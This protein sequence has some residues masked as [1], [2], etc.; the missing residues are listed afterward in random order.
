[1]S[2][3]SDTDSS[4]YNNFIRGLRGALPYL[5]EYYNET[6]V[7]KISGSTLQQQNLSGIIDDLIL[8]YRIGIKIIIVHGAGPQIRQA[9]HFHNHPG[10]TIEGRLLVAAP[11][12][13]IVQ[14]AVATANWNLITKMNRYGRDIFPFS[15]HFVQAEKTSFSEETEP[16]CT[17]KVHDINVKALQHAFSHNYLPIIA[18]FAT[19]E[20]GRL[21]I[22][23]PN[24]IAL[25][26]AVRLRTRKLVILDCE[27]NLPI[28]EVDQLRETTTKKMAQWLEKSTS[29]KIESRMQINALIEACERGVERCHLLNSSVDGAVLGEVLT[30]AGTGI[31]VTNSA[32]ERIRFA[33][34]HDIYRIT[35]I[36]DQPAN[37]SALVRKS[38]TYLEQ[39]IENFL[40]FCIDEELAGCCELIFSD[41]SKSVEIASLAVK[42]EYRNRGIGKQLIA[43]AQEQAILHHQ[44][45]LFAL[46]TK[47]SHI[48][49]ASGFKEIDPNRLPQKKRTDYDFQDSLIYGKFLA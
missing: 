25:E 4:D 33:K 24:Q 39:H 16:H 48:F 3:R 46:T 1:M 6:F 47:A 26:V 38:H 34:L 49:T 11:S 37:N 35:Q 2:G 17:G 36:L 32:Y 20:K 41:E 19:G 13:P 23:E 15:G 14:Q 12:L 18:P 40:V 21:W 22:L 31:M 27:E 8:L 43:A 28:F 30:S 29:I 45:M 7:I 42:Q 5:E 10:K 44:T 9:L